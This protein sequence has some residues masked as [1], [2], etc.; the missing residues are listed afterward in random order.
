MTTVRQ[1]LTLYNLMVLFLK[2]KLYKWL[3]LKFCID[4]ISEKYKLI[5]GFSYVHAGYYCV[6]AV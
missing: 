4:K 6:T 2:K 5:L 1:A 3:T